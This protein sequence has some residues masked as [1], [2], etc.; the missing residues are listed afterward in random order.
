MRW[1][2]A[3]GGLGLVIYAIHR[4][5]IYAA[6]RGWVYYRNGPKRGYSLGL[7]EEVFQPS[8]EHVIEEQSSEAIRADSTESGQ[9]DRSEAT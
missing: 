4:L 8:I 9:G 6:A 5:A 7:I 3:L 2:V 1:L